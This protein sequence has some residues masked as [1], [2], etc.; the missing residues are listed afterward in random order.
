MHILSVGSTGNHFWMHIC[1]LVLHQLSPT[2]LYAP[3]PGSFEFPHVVYAADVVK[4][5]IRRPMKNHRHFF[6]GHHWE[7]NVGLLHV[8]I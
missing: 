1:T 4:I 7:Y 2:Y 8:I 5:S 3:T 6:D